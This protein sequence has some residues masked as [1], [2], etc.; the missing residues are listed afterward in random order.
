M[1]RDHRGSL[2]RGKGAVRTLDNNLELMKSV[3]K[4]VAAD[5]DCFHVEG[6][7]AKCSGRAVTVE[8]RSRRRGGMKNLKIPTLI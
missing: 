7:Q 1:A 5:S 8:A 6:G 2:V 4:A 3:C